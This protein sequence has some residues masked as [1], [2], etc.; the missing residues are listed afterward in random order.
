[1]TR[2]GAPIT[3]RERHV[4]L[5]ADAVLRL[6]LEQDAAGGASVGLYVEAG[7]ARAPEPALRVPPHTLREVARALD[8]FAGELGVPP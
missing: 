2:A 7:A 1:M 4:G 8:R 6:A 5:A 3:L